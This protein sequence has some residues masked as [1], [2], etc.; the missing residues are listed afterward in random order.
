MLNIVL[1]VQNIYLDVLFNFV[2]KQIDILRLEEKKYILFLEICQSHNDE[3]DTFIKEWCKAELV[4]FDM[5]VE[6]MLLWW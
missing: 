5:K 1:L 2:N 4:G 3:A 6:M